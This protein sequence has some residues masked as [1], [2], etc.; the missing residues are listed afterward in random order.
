[1]QLLTPPPGAVTIH[2]RG[3]AHSTVVDEVLPAKPPGATTPYGLTPPALFTPE[4]SSSN[5]DLDAVA[6]KPTTLSGAPR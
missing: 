1:M 3:L 4:R 2:D 5:P 6:E